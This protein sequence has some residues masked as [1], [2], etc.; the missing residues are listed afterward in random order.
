MFCLVEVTVRQEGREE[1]CVGLRKGERE[2][3]GKGQG[4]SVVLR[5]GKIEKEKRDTPER[6]KRQVE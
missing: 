6:G 5:A 1:Q 2:G 3:E 4:Q